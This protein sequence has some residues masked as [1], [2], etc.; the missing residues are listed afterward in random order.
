MLV[1][2]ITPG[3]VGWT[4]SVTVNGVARAIESVSWDTEMARDLPEQII[5]SGGLGGASGTV[6]WA[7]QKP[8]DDRPVSPW[9]KVAGWP[10]S[11][12]DLV[13]VRVSDGVTTWTRFTGVIDNTTGDPTS[14]YQSKVI[15]F[16]DRITGSFTHEALLRHHVPFNEDGAYRSIGLDHW[17]P[18][19]A[20]LSN[21]GLHNVPPTEAN[22]ALS[23][24]MQG[25]AW[26][27][28]GTVRDVSGVVGSGPSFPWQDFG[29]AVSDVSANYAPRLSESSA[30][31]VQITVVVPGSHAGVATMDVLYGPVAIR[32]RVSEARGVTAFYSPTGSA[33]WTTVASVGG[34]SAS[35]TT[36]VQLLVK[37]G[38]WTLRTSNGAQAT[39][40]QALAAG[41][42][43][44]VLVN[45][46]T[47]SRIAGVQVSHPN[48]T[49]REFASLGFTPN[50]RFSP[51][52]LASTMDMTPALKGRAIGELVEEIL[53]ATLTASW[54]DETG[55]LILRPSNLLR[56]AA[57]VQTVTT[58]DGITA[59]AWEDALLSV[60]SA[61]EVAWKSPSIS[62]GRQYRLELWRARANTLVSNS[63][64]LEEFATPENDVEWF[65][66]NRVLR[67]LN[68]T[69]WGA[70][71]ARRGSYCGVWLSN[72]DGVPTDW[73]GTIDIVSEN[74]YSDSMKITTTVHSH[75]VAVEV[76]TETHPEEAALRPH[77]RGQP[78][79]VVRG[80]GRGEWIDATY[81]A[82]AGLATAAPILSHDLGYWGGEFFGEGSVAQRIGDYLA[83]MVTAPHPTITELGLVY[84]PRRQLGD[85]I[86]IQ[87]GWLGIELKALI[88]R[89][90]EDHGD[91]AHQSVSVRI[92]SATSTRAVTYDDLAAAWGTGNYNG[93]QAA[94]SAL[95]Y[96]ALA[97]NP[98]EGAPS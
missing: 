33:P 53:S 81:R 29:Y 73:V 13:V 48:S 4:T 90:S 18:L 89:I 61:V 24:K 70:Y 22:A 88:V 20:A 1:G 30:T 83:G 27:A 96:T 91:G 97:A 3:V 9:G 17:Y 45:A 19:T 87:S 75:P 74:L 56:S 72:A 28:A 21:A 12:G 58:A 84:D 76:N 94:W 11:V 50:M 2:D 55:T 93:L 59:L 14:G 7:T 37:G 77:L 60:R 6:S 15:D 36:V 10:P 43:S 32:L 41:S 44:T 51:S 62:K 35:A 54:W 92:I 57:P 5:A 86:T 63:D 47:A 16:R 34:Q 49:A 26:P 64:P 23:V 65:G 67:R 80:M 8:V 78:L 82:T 85:V 39:G 71:N 40:T 79:P 42:M 68:L 46:D 38:A 31:P 25:S 69:N 98:L 95:N 52:G 66:V